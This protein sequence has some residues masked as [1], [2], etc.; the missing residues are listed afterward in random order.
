MVAV[1]GEVSPLEAVHHLLCIFK[2]DF[3][4]I[5]EKKLCITC[6]KLALEDH[7]FRLG[8]QSIYSVCTKCGRLCRIVPSESEISVIVGCVCTAYGLLVLLIQKFKKFHCHTHAFYSK[9][10]AFVVW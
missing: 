8:K 1:G 10:F 5:G 6:D 7:R 3:V 4:R 9:V 2:R